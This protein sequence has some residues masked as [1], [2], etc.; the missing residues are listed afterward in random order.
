MHISRTWP[1]LKNAYWNAL[2]HSKPW[3]RIPCLP[4]GCSENAQTAPLKDGSFP[5][6]ACMQPRS[7]TTKIC[8]Q[9]FPM[10]SKKEMTCYK[11]E[12]NMQERGSRRKARGKNNC[13]RSRNLLCWGFE[14]ACIFLKT[15]SHLFFL[16]LYVT[17]K[18]SCIFEYSI[19]VHFSAGPSLICLHEVA[20]KPE[21]KLLPWVPWLHRAHMS[22][23]PA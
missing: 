5:A 3:L 6:Y 9:L 1:D 14:G 2:G 15:I 21:G 20:T 18:S 22:G 8:Q 17:P 19:V 11:S 23:R 16:A 7:T 13:N 4:C 10:P 12:R